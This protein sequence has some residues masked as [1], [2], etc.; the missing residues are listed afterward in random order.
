MGNNGQIPALLVGRKVQ[1]HHRK[2]STGLLS[3]REIRRVGTKM[4]LTVRTV[5]FWHPVQT[6]KDQPCWGPFPHAAQTLSWTPP[7][8]GATRGSHCQCSPVRAAGCRPH[9]HCWCPWRHHGSCVAP[10][11][12]GGTWSNGCSRGCKWGTPQTVS[13]WL[14]AATATRSSPWPGAR[15]LASQALR[16]QGTPSAPCEHWCSSTLD[17][18]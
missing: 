11:Q 15:S 17:C 2:Q 8:S 1:G 4:G 18:S 10:G 16:H 6:W 9:T 13:G 5:R 12:G 14:A 7:D 3:L